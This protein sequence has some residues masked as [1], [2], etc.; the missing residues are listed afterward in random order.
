MIAPED[1]IAAIARIVSRDNAD[2][3]IGDSMD[4]IQRM[5]ISDISNIEGDIVI[6]TARPGI[7]I[8]YKGQFYRKLAKE[9]GQEFTIV[10]KSDFTDRL[11]IA[12]SNEYGD[13]YSSEADVAIYDEFA[14]DM[15]RQYELDTQEYPEEDHCD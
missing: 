15:T 12:V 6:T 8:G 2:G 10:E 9:I 5:R 3:R 11:E 14:A 13:F 7:L 1:V 4:Y